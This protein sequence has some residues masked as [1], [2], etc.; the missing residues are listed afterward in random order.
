[1]VLYRIWPSTDGSA[2]A[3]EDDPV[4]LG[5]EFFVTQQAWVTAMHIWRFDSTMSGTVRGRIWIAS[6]GSEGQPLA[7]TDVTFNIGGTG[8]LTADLEE[9]V[10]LTPIVRYRASMH[11]SSGYTGTGSYWTSGPGSSG[12]TNGIIT[13]PASGPGGDQSGTQGSFAYAADYSYPN[14]TFQGGNYWVD[15]TVSDVFPAPVGGNLSISDTARA[16]MIAALGLS[17]AQARVLS[18]VD[19]MRLVI[20]AGGLGLVTVTSATAAV[21]LERY[22]RFLRSGV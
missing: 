19:L 9:P 3:A 13:A 20:A 15:V 4:N 12:I 17:D 16:N 18:N 7:G 21:H 14:S 2:F 1:M 5:T 6:G 11:C 8:W 10:E 22:L